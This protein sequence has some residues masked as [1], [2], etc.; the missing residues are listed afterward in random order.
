MATVPEF[1]LSKLGVVFQPM[2]EQPAEGLH[3]LRIVPNT[4]SVGVDE[5]ATAN[6]ADRAECV[7]T[8]QHLNEQATCP[9]AFTY[10]CFVGKPRGF[11]YHSEGRIPAHEE[12]Q[13]M[14]FV[15]DSS[16]VHALKL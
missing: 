15:E 14:C 5:G 11:T 3:R 9:F 16:A 2:P 13:C 8:R 4:T 7:R 6:H 10:A 12:F 1:T